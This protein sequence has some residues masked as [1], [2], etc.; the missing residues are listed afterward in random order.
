[1]AENYTIN[2]PRLPTHGPQ[3]ASCATAW[4]TFGGNVLRCPACTQ[5]ACLGGLTH[6]GTQQRIYLNCGTVAHSEC[7]GMY[8]PHSSGMPG[9]MACT[10]IKAG[11][12]L[13]AAHKPH[14]PSSIR[15]CKDSL[16]SHQFGQHEVGAYPSSCCSPDSTHPG[17]WLER[18][19]WRGGGIYTKAP[20]RR[21]TCP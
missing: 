6:A 9:H 21:R 19:N 10:I 20:L 4:H 18:H 12:R 16:P 8:S 14:T 2:N 7:P 17:G 3:A 11:N 15:S 1:M 13:V 5:G